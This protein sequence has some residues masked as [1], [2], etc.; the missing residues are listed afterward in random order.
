MTTAENPRRTPLY[1][2]HLAA[3]GRLVPF[4]DFL[5]PTHYT[6]LAEEHTAVR[7]RAGLF[8]VSHMG[9]I[10]VRGSGAFEF[11]QRISCND[12]SKLAVGRAQYTGV[13]YPEGTFVDDLLAHRTGDDEYLL[14]VNAANTAKDFSYLSESAAGDSGVEILDRSDEF[15]QIA[16]QGPLASEILQPL[17]AVAVDEIKYYR[18]TWGEVAGQHCLIARTG[19]TGEDGFELYLAPEGGEGRFHR[20]RCARETA[21]RGRHTPAGG[22]RNG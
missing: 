9:E 18:F 19:Y 21:V 6:S 12:H 13:M 20:S 5:L 15:A 22:L 16:L 17:T 14:V 7:T 1:D 10:V 11:I 8:D 4:A 3:G 2:E